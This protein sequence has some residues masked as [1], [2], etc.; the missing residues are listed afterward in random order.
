MASRDQTPTDEAGSSA[1]RP[2]P[3]LSNAPTL[4]TAAP[5]APT[6]S[7]LALSNLSFDFRAAQEHNI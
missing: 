5:Q 6:Q 1:T 4:N 2:P 3:R 7:T